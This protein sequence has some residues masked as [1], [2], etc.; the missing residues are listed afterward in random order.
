MLDEHGSNTGAW[1]RA[2]KT[3]EGSAQRETT[4]APG[5]VKEA[6]REAAQRAQPRGRGAATGSERV[7]VP[8]LQASAFL[9]R[10]RFGWLPA[11]TF[12][13]MADSRRWRAGVV[14]ASLR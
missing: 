5:G 2:G 4:E 7:K 10:W 12:A 1:E 8:W 9:S 11:Y 3:A 6:C 14:A 13:P